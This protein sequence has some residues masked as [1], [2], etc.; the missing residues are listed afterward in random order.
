MIFF[1]KFAMIIEQESLNI[2]L[3]SEKG[4][5]II[6][7][8]YFILRALLGQGIQIYEKKLKTY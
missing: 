3:D 4:I 7:F 2:S 8:Y 5:M 6:I 1:L